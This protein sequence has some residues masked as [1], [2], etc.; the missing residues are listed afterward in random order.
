MG[1]DGD[2]AVGVKDGFVF[3]HEIDGA[4]QLDGEHRIGFEF[5]AV[6]LRLQALR[7]RAEDIMIPFGDDGGFAEGPTEVRVAQFG[8][9]QAL[10]LA[11]TGHGAF[12][13]ATVGEEIL[14]GGEAGDV[15][16]FIEDGHAEVFA[17]AGDGLEQGILAGEGLFGEAVELFFQGGDLGIEMA[18]HGQLVL[19]GQLAEGMG[20]V[21]EEFFFPGIAVGAGLAEG[22]TVMGQL[23]GLDAG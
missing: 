13:Q 5:V 14:D 22:G 2:Q 15:A 23:D 20:F 17:D 21:S 10:D 8:A 19:E 11:G 6:H 1:Q 7:Q 3:E 12:N 4:S 18:D 9:A 16:D